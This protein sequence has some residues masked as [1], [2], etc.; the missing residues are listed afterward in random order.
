MRVLSHGTEIVLQVI[1]YIL[2]WGL[3]CLLSDWYY[4]MLQVTVN[5]FSGI[6]LISKLQTEGG[7]QDLITS[8]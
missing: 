7:K 2:D 4:R 1:Q 5:S 8:C 3:G 6:G